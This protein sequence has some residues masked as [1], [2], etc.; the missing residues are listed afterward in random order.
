MMT[1]SISINKYIYSLLTADPTL[2]E[3]T[4]GDIYPI[5]A[6]ES[7]SYPF[8]L[9]TK[10]NA[11]GNYTKDLLLYDSATV[12]VVIAAVNYFQTVEIAERVR[13]VLE[14]YRDGYFNSITL[15]NVSEDFSDDAY[16]Q[17]LTF[18]VKIN[19]IPTEEEEEKE[20]NTEENNTDLNNI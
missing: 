7:V 4:G 1:T 6:E 5:V 19:P 2:M 11:Y 17:Q 12:E 18:S 16:I 8:V 9:F 20:N 14:A 13:Q 10:S 3:L 15:D